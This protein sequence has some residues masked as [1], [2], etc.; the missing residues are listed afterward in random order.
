[1]DNREQQ[2]L[3]RA[4]FAAASLD[5]VADVELVRRVAS[6]SDRAA[7][8][9]LLWRHGPLV[10]ATCRRILGH[11]SDAEDVF[12]VVFHTLSRRAGAIADGTAVASWLYRITIR[13]A[14]KAARV[15]SRRAQRESPCDTLPVLASDDDPVRVAVGREV[16][17]ILD[18]EIARLP[19]RFRLPF[20]MCELNGQDQV[21]VAA[22]LG[23]AAG[24]VASRLSRAK[25]RLRSRLRGRGLILPTA[26]TLVTVPASLQARA[27][28][29]AFSSQVMLPSG[30][31]EWAA[32]A[33]IGGVA[34]PVKAIA[35]TLALAAGTIGLFAQTPKAPPAE[36]RPT[37]MTPPKETTPTASMP[38]PE[39]AVAQLGSAGLRHPGMVMAATYSPDGK[40]IATAGS[41]RTARVWNSHTGELRYR[42]TIPGDASQ[43][44]V[45]FMDDGKVLW[46]MPS[47]YPRLNQVRRYSMADGK[48]L[49]SVLPATVDERRNLT[50]AGFDPSGHVFAYVK[51]ELLS[52]SEIT[53][54]DAASG[55]QL[56]QFTVQGEWSMEPVLA[57]GGKVVACPSNP[58]SKTD[59][60]VR[61]FRAETGAEIATFDTEAAVQA[62]VIS[63][64]GRMVATTSALPRDKPRAASIWDATTGKLIRHLE[65]P[66]AGR[67]LAFS[68]DGKQ[69]AVA[70]SGGYG[71]VMVFDVD[72]GKELRR[73]PSRPS[74]TEIAF[75]PDGAKLVGS[76]SI[77][78]VSVWDVASGEPVPPSA[79]PDLMF[80]IKFLDAGHLLFNVNGAAV[81]YDW[82][83]GRVTERSAAPKTPANV[84]RLRYTFAPDRKLQAEWHLHPV[85]RL[86]DYE[87]G[88][89]IRQ[90]K[91][92]TKEV[93]M[94][95]FSADGSKIF[96]LGYDQTFRVWDTATG[97][98][99][100]LL[101]VGESK[102]RGEF[103][104]SPDERWLSVDLGTPGEPVLRVWD[105]QT[106][107]EGKPPE[108]P[109]EFVH[110][111]AFT[112]DG[113]RLI[114]TGGT[115]A[116]VLSSKEASAG[117]LL[118][119]DLTTQSVHTKRS[120]PG[121][122]ATS[123]ISTDDRTLLTG[124][125][126]GA[127]RLWEL[128]T[129]TERRAFHGHDSQVFQVVASLTGRHLASGGA[130]GRTFIWDAYASQSVVA[131]D[132]AQLWTD[133]A[134]SEGNKAFKAMCHL[135]ARPTQAVAMIRERLQPA[136]AI[137]PKRLQEL[138]QALDSDRFAIREQA[139]ADLRRLGHEAETAIRRKLEDKPSAEAKERLMGLLV[140]MPAFSSDE[141]REM[142]A[143]EVLERIASPDAVDLL[144][145]WAGDASIRIAK[146]AAAAGKRLKRP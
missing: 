28:R 128:A 130:D 33:S 78:T 24:T 43:A 127:I 89:E 48:E 95:R 93:A 70:N 51:Y 118:I 111:C 120:V 107:R 129:G 64:D 21:A 9:L 103:E 32:K 100:R 71:P 79:E 116:R 7:F 20:I 35:I 11:T 56:A 81:A 97:A 27:A 91:G 82:R 137:D 68:P 2:L 139:T 140:K 125:F 15:R 41:D 101:N 6:L 74:V 69:L 16:G 131:I 18:A 19:E 1:M 59:G 146:D 55:K 61:L 8:E 126:D 31:V 144:K 58:V 132:L 76:R 25:Q 13:T 17:A 106:G 39:G 42:F 37:P 67:S 115:R 14:L 90:L 104:V 102:I 45:A 54:I 77:G 83:T 50:G 124:G 73:L 99:L 109:S 142:R 46:V 117:W 145:K 119:W 113:T 134:A 38:L 62:T 133:L 72:S 96:S 22:E 4:T 29:V 87:T 5:A 65:G 66:V 122:A 34:S 105:L 123:A 60:K 135:T 3:F 47:R 57:P 114:V 108:L 112:R 12:Q 84:D 143:V 10:W 80:P 63:P 40:W 138:I 36:N 30:L 121:G 53:L 136:P 85:I 44:R 98:Q 92:H 94:V 86:C 26:F 141:L 52:S 110:S 75:S 49:P 88:A 23:C